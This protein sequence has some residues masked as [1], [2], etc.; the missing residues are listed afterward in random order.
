L[1][2]GL[3]SYERGTRTA[4]D[5]VTVSIALDG[6]ALPPPGAGGGTTIPTKPVANTLADTGSDVGP[7]LA[8]GALLVLLGTGLLIVRRP[9]A[10]T[11]G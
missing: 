1:N 6:A 3:A 5:P 7:L 4:L 11:V 2:V 10:T 9:R 8:A